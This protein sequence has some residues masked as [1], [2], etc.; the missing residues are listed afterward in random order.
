MTIAERI[1]S[2]EKFGIKPGLERIS[3]MLDYLDHPEKAY[4]IIIVG[5]TNGKG[6]TCSMIDSI[7]RSSGYKT[8]LYTSPHLV[9]MQERIKVNGEMID[10]ASFDAT[11]ERLFDIIG[12]RAELSDLTYFEFMTAAALLHFNKLKIDIA[13]L[14]VGM[15]G[16]FDATNAVQ[17]D[18]S[19]ITNIALDHQLYLGT[20]EQEIAREKA[21]IIRSGKPF[22]TTDMNPVSRQVLEV[23]CANKHGILYAMDSAFSIS[24]TEA[25]FSFYNDR[26]AIEG[27]RLALKGRHQISNAA[28]AIQ[29]VLLIDETVTKI[30]DN[31]IRDGLLKTSWPGRFE[32]IRKNPDVILDSAHN[33]A[34][35]QTLIKTV[36]DYYLT[37]LHPPYQ[38]ESN[39]GL[40]SYPGQ[41]KSVTVVF[42]VSKDKQWQSMITQLSEIADTFVLTSYTGERSAAPEELAGFIRSIR[43]SSPDRLH[44]ISSSQSALNHALAITPAHGVI[45][46]TGSIFLIGEIKMEI[47]V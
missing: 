22:V 41:T 13:I 23:E 36:K 29:A 46:V 37:P 44:V 25:D 39:R 14:E 38:G 9:S 42:A 35:I 26:R 5:G 17:P 45:V 19:V 10:Q 2:L 6:S 21:G 28:A 12:S 7:L 33:P 20:T 15:G 43:L 47:Q 18:I 32:I 40:P 27:L 4:K 3:A 11:G 34:G 24:G 1:Q 8:G 16:R 31:S 30:A